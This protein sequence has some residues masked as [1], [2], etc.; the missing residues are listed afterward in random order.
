MKNDF[1]F[2]YICDCLF[3]NIL[4][5]LKTLDVCRSIIL[6]SNRFRHL[7]F[8]RDDKKIQMVKD[9]ISY[10]FGQFESSENNIINFN[11][12]STVGDKVFPYEYLKSSY[13]MFK[14]FKIGAKIQVNMLDI[15]TSPIEIFIHRKKM[16]FVK[17]EIC[18]I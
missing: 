6:V 1:L 3:Y 14:Y 12:Y 7:F 4:R 18:K 11:F 15:V 10:D 16:S 13:H 8:D 9:I 2:L 5:Y 17:Y